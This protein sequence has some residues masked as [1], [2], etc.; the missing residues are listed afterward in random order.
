MLPRFRTAFLLGAAALS[1]ALLAPIPSARSATPDQVENEIATMKQGI[2]NA[3]QQL[4]ALLESGDPSRSR[5]A[6]NAA[7]ALKAEIAARTADLEKLEQMLVDIREHEAKRNVANEINGLKQ[8]LE[9][10]RG[11]IAALNEQ[12]AALEREREEEPIRDD[13]IIRVYRL[14]YMQAA[15]AAQTLVELFGNSPIRIAVDERANSIVVAAPE[16]ER[17]FETVNAVIENLD[18]AT[19]EGDFAPADQA[20]EDYTHAKATQSLLVR[21]YWLADGVAEDEGTAPTGAL[22]QSV[23][24]AVGKLGLKSPRL[25]GQT[26]NSLSRDGNPDNKVVFE[27]RIPALL[28]KRPVQLRCGGDISPIRDGRV[29]LSIQLQ[30]E[31]HQLDTELSGSLTVPLGHYMVLG[32]ANSVSEELSTRQAELEMR[33]RQEAERERGEGFGGGR[34]GF[35]GGFGG[36]RGYDG[37]RGGDEDMF[38]LR[39]ESTYATSHFAFVVQVVEGES[40]AAE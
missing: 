24:D 40:F 18:V 39:P 37:G 14:K 34:G 9:E 13:A 16:H 21:V 2:L 32:T 20:A 38:A 8:Q 1:V 5:N 28:F 23:V 19:G 29:D 25:V 33:R 35:D 30:A 11:Q 6:K 7:D 17:Y 4:L 31:G 10:S 22:P 3:Q 12:L 27:T 26:V 15:K 36:G